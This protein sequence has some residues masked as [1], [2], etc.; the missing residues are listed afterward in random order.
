MHDHNSPEIKLIP[1]VKQFCQEKFP[2]CV[3][4]FHPSVFFNDKTFKDDSWDEADARIQLGTNPKT[5]QICEVTPDYG[6]FRAEDIIGIRMVIGNKVHRELPLIKPGT[7][8]FSFLTE[9]C[10]PI[11]YIAWNGHVEIVPNGKVMVVVLKDKTFPVAVIDH[12]G[13]RTYN[14]QSQRKKALAQARRFGASVS[15]MLTEASLPEPV[16]CDGEV[17]ASVFA[18]Y[19]DCTIW[20]LKRK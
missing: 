18:T 2:G 6:I 7:P 1:T 13:G 15:Y 11:P 16:R 20:E 9:F 4:I 12:K 19:P 3:M 14:I 17:S 10:D 8:Q 5:K